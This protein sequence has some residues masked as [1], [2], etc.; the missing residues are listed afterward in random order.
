MPE[1][2]SEPLSELELEASL[3]EMPEL[4]LELS[5]AIRPLSQRAR[6]LEGVFRRD[7]TVTVK[8]SLDL[9]LLLLPLVLLLQERKRHYDKPK[10]SSPFSINFKRMV[11]C[12]K[13]VEYYSNAGFF[14]PF[15]ATVAQT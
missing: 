7:R 5:E 12:G 2:L 4:V 14:W 10:N 13:L 1:S 9:A 3:S 11:S 15:V 8:S 6:S